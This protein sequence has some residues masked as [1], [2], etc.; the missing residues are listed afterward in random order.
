MKSFS[1][2]GFRRAV[3]VDELAALTGHGLP[4]CHISAVQRLAGQAGKAQLRQALARGDARC[5]HVLHLAQG[6]REQAKQRGHGMHEADAL[7]PQP[8][9]QARGVLAHS[10]VGNHQ[11]AT[12]QQR[13]QDF[14]QAYVKG[15][16][17]E[18]A[19]PHVGGQA[20]FGNFPV[21]KM[22][23][24]L[25]APGNHFRLAGRS[26]GVYQV[27][28]VVLSGDDVQRLSGWRLAAAVHAQ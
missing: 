14:A 23:H 17:R 22:A 12:S 18:D 6:A 8:V 1:Q 3:K 28:S 15:G 21:H 19:G 24:A 9:A 20:Q 7:K 27:A 10:D 13:H 2:R 5:A 25:V 26:R 4:G 11:A 16:W